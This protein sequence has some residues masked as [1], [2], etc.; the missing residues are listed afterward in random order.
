LS[1]TETVIDILEPDQ[2][3]IELI[4]VLGALADP[5]RLA[6]VQALAK[7]GSWAWCGQILKDSDIN[8]SKS[9]LSHHLRVLRNA[10]L[11]HTRID[12]SRRYV[13]LRREDLDTRFPGLL[14]IVCGEPS[15]AEFALADRG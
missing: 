6:Y 1:Y 5:V 10:G 12:G 15:P 14:R 7:A 2:E 11:T 8:I 4:D 9:T 13:T 3:H